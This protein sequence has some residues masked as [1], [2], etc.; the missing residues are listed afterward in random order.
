M[1]LLKIGL[2]IYHMNLSKIRLNI[3]YNLLKIRLDISYESFG[4]KKV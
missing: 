4:K 1:N 2:D 3:S